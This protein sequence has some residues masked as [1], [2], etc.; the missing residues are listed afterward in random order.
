MLKLEL[1][2]LVPEAPEDDEETPAAYNFR[3]P[4]LKQPGFQEV[5][6]RVIPDSPRRSPIKVQN[7]NEQSLILPNI[8][9]VVEENPKWLTL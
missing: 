3:R 7:G 1:Q 5:I 8:K 9:T 4:A 6:L 2:G